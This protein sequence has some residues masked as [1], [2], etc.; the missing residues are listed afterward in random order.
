[1]ITQTAILAGLLLSAQDTTQPAPQPE[2]EPAQTSDTQQAA[3][4][5]E[6]GDSDA[7]TDNRDNEVVCRRTQVIGSRFTRRVC[8]TRK[9]WADLAKRSRE[10]TGEI[11]RRGAGLEPDGG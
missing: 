1:M 6:N 9:E 7:E 11:Q 4:P 2:A 10:T 3:A 5:Q 8:A